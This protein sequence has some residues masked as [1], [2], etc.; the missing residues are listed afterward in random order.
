MQNRAGL[1]LTGQKHRKARDN[2]RRP[3]IAAHSVYG[4]N[5]CGVGR[6]VRFCLG[7]VLNVQLMLRRRPV[8]RQRTRLLRVWH[9]GCKTG[10]CGVG[11]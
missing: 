2:S 10:K 1:W 4:Y 3:F 11:A 5:M 6:D 9:S 8:P 7:H